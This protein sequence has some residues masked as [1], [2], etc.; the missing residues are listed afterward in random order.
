MFVCVCVCVF[1][2]YRHNQL[3]WSRKCFFFLNRK[4]KQSMFVL[5]FSYGL[6][7][8]LIPSIL[9]TSKNW[10]VMVLLLKSQEKRV[11]DFYY[12]R[13]K[14]FFCLLF[15]DSCRIYDNESI[16]PVCSC[17]PMFTQNEIIRFLYNFTEKE[18][19]KKTI[20]LLCFVPDW[21]KYIVSC[22]GWQT[23]KWKWPFNRTYVRTHKTASHFV[24]ENKESIFIAEND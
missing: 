6:W 9:L 7:V 2:S 17:V 1:L 10:S 16:C 23:Q 14:L 11:A 22:F 13:K 20:L 12:E 24:W 8:T 5:H 15:S 4:T 21:T 3:N 19:K 18:K